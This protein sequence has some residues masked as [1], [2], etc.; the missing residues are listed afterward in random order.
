MQP[1]RLPSHARLL[2]LTRPHAHHGVPAF[3]CLHGYPLVPTYPCISTLLSLLPSALHYFKFSTP[4]LL[5]PPAAV[6]RALPSVPH[7]SF[8]LSDSPITMALLRGNRS[9]AEELFVSEPSHT[10]LIVRCRASTPLLYDS[11]ENWPQKL[12]DARIVPVM[13]H[14]N[15]PPGRDRENS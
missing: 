10:N 5:L 4:Q 7:S 15:H 9:S 6:R 12:P 13:G 2:S 11:Y 3:S 8:P 1:I 14:G